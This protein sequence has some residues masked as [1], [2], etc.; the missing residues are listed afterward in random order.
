MRLLT[1]FFALLFAASAAA[2][3][4]ASAAGDQPLVR[5]LFDWDEGRPWLKASITLDQA[6]KTH[7][8]GTPNP[9]DGG[10]SDP[11]QQDF[12]MSQ[13]NCSKIFELAKKLNYFQGDFDSHLKRIAKT[14]SK[15]LEYTSTTTHG[16]STYNWSPNTDVQELTR[17][18]GGIASTIDYGRKLA[19]QYRFDKL[20]METR[21]KELEELKANHYAEELDAI[22]PILRKIANDPNMMNISRQAAQHLLA[23]TVGSGQAGEASAHP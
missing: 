21:L 9:V 14:G 20:G 5:Y 2:Q 23:S 8:E 16:S 15:T 11:F 3:Q 13:A 6:C 17:I 7:F 18:F 22:A 10:D 19:F 12:V 4:P 1:T